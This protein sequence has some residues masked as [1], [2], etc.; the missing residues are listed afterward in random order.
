MEIKALLQ[1][2]SSLD[3]WA[4]GVQETDLSLWHVMLLGL[5]STK[6]DF[7]LQAFWGHFTLCF[8]ARQLQSVFRHCVSDLCARKNT[9]PTRLRCYPGNRHTDIL[10]GYSEYYINSCTQIASYPADS[11]SH[12]YSRSLPAAL[13][14]HSE[15]ET[16]VIVFLEIPLRIW[17]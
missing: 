16:K 17:V 10:N 5:I 6:W 1:H 8:A 2:I 11:S 4:G 15:S 12:Q 13:Q 14:T 7:P 9:S 3:E